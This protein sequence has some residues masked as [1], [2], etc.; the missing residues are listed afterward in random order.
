MGEKGKY[1]LF[2]DLFLKYLHILAVVGL[3]CCVHAYSSCDKWGLLS[4]CGTGFSLQWLLLL[5]GTWASVV[6][7]HRPQSAGIVVMAHR[8]SWS[9]AC[10]IFL[11]QGSN[12]CPLDC[13]VDS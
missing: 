9:A 1:I 10:G 3:H 12:R 5:E 7:A 6:R 2:F 13:K 8:L 4:V 11:D